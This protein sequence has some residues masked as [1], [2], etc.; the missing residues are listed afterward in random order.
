MLNI[1]RPD[2]RF[3]ALKKNYRHALGCT[4]NRFVQNAAQFCFRPRLEKA[5]TLLTKAKFE[6][7]SLVD[8]SVAP[9]DSPE[10]VIKKAGHVTLLPP[11]TS[12]GGQYDTIFSSPFNYILRAAFVGE[13][14][15]GL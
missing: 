1:G 14:I 6:G 4:S 7:L 2:L 12:H 15:S 9:R 3:F 8:T 5:L 10:A 13:I 11:Y